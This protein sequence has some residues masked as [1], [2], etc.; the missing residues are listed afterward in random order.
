MAAP[1][2]NYTG[3]TFLPDLVTRPEFLSYISEEIFERCAWIQSGV[4][5]RNNALD[6]RAGGVR[7]RVPFFQP[8]NPTEEIIESNSSWGTS[9]AGYLTPQKVTADEQIMTI[10]HRGFSYAVDDL[11]AMGSGADPMAAIRGYL[12]RAILKLRT[13]T[14]LSQLEGLFGTALADNVV[15]KC[16]GTTAPDETNYMTASVFAEARAKLGERGEDITA[17][18]MHSSVYY[19]LVQ[20]GALTFSSSSLVSG[21][22]I[23]WGGGGINLRNDDVSYFMGAR[24]IVDDM[25]APLNEGTTG[26][27]PCFPVYAFGGGSVMEGVQQELRTEVDRNILSKQDVM[28]LDYHYG[29]HVMGSSWSAAGD[30]PANADLE[31]SGNW[32]LVYQTSK[33]VPIVQIKVNT[34]IAGTVYP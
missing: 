32:D 18:A 8:I 26:E 25:L 4:M 21:G 9:G 5:V 23:E 34:P 12:S 31:T 19:Y 27:Y 15:D 10:M 6:C 24:V 7:V 2:Q 29:M 16:S 14:L 33:L 13:T 30:N 11:S 17:V 1:F 20:V 3:G 28:S 22:Q